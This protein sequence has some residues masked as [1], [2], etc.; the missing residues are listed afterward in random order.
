MIPFE[1][2]QQSIA[3]EESISAVSRMIKRGVSRKHIPG[4]ALFMVGL[5][6]M[7]AN[8]TRKAIAIWLEELATRYRA[9]IN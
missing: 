3:L 5:A 6:L 2:K 9:S 7:E 1:F 4:S 8:V